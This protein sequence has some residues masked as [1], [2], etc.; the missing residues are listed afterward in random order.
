M[1]TEEYPL[2]RRLY[3]YTVGEPKEPLA[4]GLLEYALSPAVQSVIR[5]NDFVDQIPE[6]LDFQ[7]QTT[8]IAY[9]LNAAG[10]D[11]DLALMKS[12]ISDF[13]PASRM[14]T[15]FRF[16]TANFALDS[17]A[18][19]DVVRL[20]S[21]L[22]Q[23]EYKGKTVMLAGFADGVGRFDS[24]LILSQ[25]RAATVLGAL[26]KVNTKP[27]PVNIVTKAYSQLAPVACND[28]PEQRGFNRRV[29]VWVK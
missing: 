19:A 2:T 5:Q 14:T 7:A 1:K 26:Q 3:L 20:R 24:N 23:P 4:K 13:K 11:F 15:T 22:E 18:T 28:T 10:P 8:R 17:K 25:R 29:E 12:L 27:L 9:A 16:E 6:L 21:L